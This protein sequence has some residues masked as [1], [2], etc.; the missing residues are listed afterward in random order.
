MSSEKP[1][2]RASIVDASRE[3]LGRACIEMFSMRALQQTHSMRF[4]T[5][6]ALE[7]CTA[8]RRWPVDV[9]T[10]RAI[11]PGA[12]CDLPTIVSVVPRWCEYTSGYDALTYVTTLIDSTVAAF[13]K[14]LTRPAPNPPCFPRFTPKH[15]STPFC[16][17]Q[18]KRFSYAYDATLRSMRET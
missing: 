15:D 13:G 18:M 6:S 4:L 8:T 14:P 5:R 3:T 7:W 16:E 17:H 9:R 10:H 1:P 12:T 2:R 11:S